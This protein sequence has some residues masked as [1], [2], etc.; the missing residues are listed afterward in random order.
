M[1]GEEDGPALGTDLPHDVLEHQGGRRVQAHEGLIQ[2]QELWL[3]DEG[4]ED[5]QLL[6]HAVGVGGDQVPQ[7]GRE[8]EGVGVLPDEG[9]P[10]PGGDGKH[11]G[12]EVQILDAGEIL[13]KVGVVGDVGHLLLAAHRV[14]GEVL[15]A[16]G[17]GAGIPALDAGH[18]LESGGLAGA[19]VADEGVEVPGL[20]VEGQV[21]D[22]LGAALVVLGEAIDVKHE[23]NSFQSRT[24]EP[25]LLSLNFFCFAR[26]YPGTTSSS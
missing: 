11:V 16:N 22:P 24:K 18:A 10:L 17:D 8:L 5:G 1:G 19:V 7:G 6:L 21:G 20:D 12:N 25:F 23:K 2:Q 26:P 3:V 14:R 15:A 9:L 4:R 13:V